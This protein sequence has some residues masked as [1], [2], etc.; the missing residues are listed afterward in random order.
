VR[1]AAGVS[2]ERLRKYGPTHSASL[3]PFVGKFILEPPSRF[4]SLDHLVGER[5]QLVRHGKAECLG[6]LD[7]DDEVKLGRLHHW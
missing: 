3:Q 2:A 5:E 7:I 4:T 1:H 6:G